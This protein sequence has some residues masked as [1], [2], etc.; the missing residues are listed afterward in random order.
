[1]VCCACYETVAVHNARIGVEWSC[2][3][4]GRFGGVDVER[5]Y[6]PW[7]RPSDCSIA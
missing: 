4:S 7:A 3:S 1:M 2:I 6:L 5:E